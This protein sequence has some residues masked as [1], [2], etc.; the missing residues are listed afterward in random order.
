MPAQSG[1]NRIL[2]LMNRTY[3][4]EWYLDRISSIR[5]ILGT[6]CGISHDM[7]AGF[8]TENETDHQD[9]LSIMEHCKYDM[10][11]MYF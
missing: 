6:D 5:T 10:S 11:Y 8:C 7:I 9:T 4:R 1:S 2:K 3:T